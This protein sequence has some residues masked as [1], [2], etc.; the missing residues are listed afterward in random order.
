MLLPQ[1]LP[2][3][4]E[5]RFFFYAVLN[6]AHFYMCCWSPACALSQLLTQKLISEELPGSSGSGSHSGVVLS[7]Q[8]ERLRWETLS[9]LEMW[10]S[11]RAFWGEK[12]L[13]MT[14]LPVFGTVSM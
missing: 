2:C 10:N 8:P 6:K 13:L 3:S 14:I 11:S 7:A 5:G 1:T 4:R 12:C 9:Y